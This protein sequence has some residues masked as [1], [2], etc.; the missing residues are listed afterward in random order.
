MR[1]VEIT[2]ELRRRGL[3]ANGKKAEAVDRLVED[4]LKQSGSSI[5]GSS[6][7]SQQSSGSEAENM[8]A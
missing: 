5:S 3:P 4:M 6:S 2:Q 1:Y 8:E 7:S